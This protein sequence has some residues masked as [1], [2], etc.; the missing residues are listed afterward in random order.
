MGPAPEAELGCGNPASNSTLVWRVR[1]PS[2]SENLLQ[3]GVKIHLLLYLVQSRVWAR[4][5]ACPADK[6]ASGDYV[7][8]Q[9]S[10]A[11]AMY[12]ARAGHLHAIILLNQCMAYAANASFSPL[13]SFGPCG[14]PSSSLS[15]HFMLRNR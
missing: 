9:S 8:A 11:T 12:V 1:R 3:E 14:Y 15:R 10:S 7:L 6:P 5:L 4:D 13:T 2:E